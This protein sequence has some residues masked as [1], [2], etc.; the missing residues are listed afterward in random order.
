MFS[1]NWLRVAVAGVTAGGYDR[2]VNRRRIRIVFG[3]VVFVLWV[4]C[5]VFVVRFDFAHGSF[6]PWTIIILIV[7][8]FLAFMRLVRVWFNEPPVE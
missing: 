1:P 2:S 8:G 7:S 4:L 5:A 3:G 6:G